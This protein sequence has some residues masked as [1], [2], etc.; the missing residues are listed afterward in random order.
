MVRNVQATSAV[1]Y[2]GQ[3]DE[4]SLISA[5]ENGNQQIYKFR[6]KLWL[7]MKSDVPFLWIGHEDIVSSLIRSGVN[8]NEMQD[9]DTLLHTVANAGIKCSWMHLKNFPCNPNPIEN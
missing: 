4:S 7:L 9:G 3:T 6:F 5:V 2:S 8:V 1:G